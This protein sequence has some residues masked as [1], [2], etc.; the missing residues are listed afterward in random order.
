MASQKI[1]IGD[2]VSV[3]DDQLEGE[4]IRIDGNIITFQDEH[5]FDYQMPA[6]R[7]VVIG[8]DLT[9]HLPGSYVPVQKEDDLLQPPPNPTLPDTLDLH[10]DKLDIEH[11]PSGEILQAQLRKLKQYL[12]SIRQKHYKTFTIIHGQGQGVLKKEV[13]KILRRKGFKNY[14]EI[15]Q[16]SIKVENIK[17]KKL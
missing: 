3:I 6:E 12:D 5:G 9:I 8:K 16:G 1:Q 14:W 10:A 4:V 11:L 2:R 17:R 7:L 13:I 15:N